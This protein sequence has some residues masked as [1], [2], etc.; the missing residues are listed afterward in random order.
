M[1]YLL[2]FRK[3]Q[4][5]R[6]LLIKG[7]FYMQ[8]GIDIGGSHIGIALIE[9]GKIITLQEKDMKIGNE[10]ERENFLLE[11]LKNMMYEILE[12]TKIDLSQIDLIGI[13]IP[14]TT[15]KGVVLHAPNIKIHNFNICEELEKEFNIKIQIRNDAKCAAMAEKNFGALKNAKDAIF[16]TIGTGIG[17]AVFI[18]GKMLKPAKNDA[19][20]IGHMVIQKN[21]K[22]C[23][24]GRKGCFETYASMKTLK[25]NIRDY[26]G[27]EALI[28]E[29]QEIVQCDEKQNMIEEYLENLSVGLENLINLF[30]PEVIAFGGSFSMYEGILIKRTEEMLKRRSAVMNQTIPTLV[31]AE[32]KNNAGIIGAICEEE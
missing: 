1:S 14:G 29:I 2:L 26:L 18:D 27:R 24:C 3:I 28:E 23:N 31:A 16:L 4:F 17:G 20:E 15:S 11:Q 10:T 7:G 19:F 32:L 6:Q 12:K 21:G 8:I 30:E 25:D 22:L 13:A 9:K 5:I